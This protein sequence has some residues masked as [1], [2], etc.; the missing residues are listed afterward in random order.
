MSQSKRN[1]YDYLGWVLEKVPTLPFDP[2]FRCGD[3]DLQQYFNRDSVLYQKELLTQSYRFYQ[4]DL[5]EIT[6][7]RVDFCNDALLREEMGSGVKGKINNNKRFLKSFPAIKIT[8]LGVQEK[9]HRMGVGSKLLN[10]VKLLFLTDNRTGCRF[11]TVDAYEDAV[12]FY[13]RNGFRPLL[14]KREI[15]NLKKEQD[16]EIALSL[17]THKDDP[18]RKRTI[19]LLFDLKSL[20]DPATGEVI[21]PKS[22]D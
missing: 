4:E 19:P 12:P 5:P 6:A 7:A 11:L 1:R 20:C 9:L 21:A 14:V 13:T 15:A 3:E 2:D 16:R 8:R 22:A 18:P 10:I 17:E